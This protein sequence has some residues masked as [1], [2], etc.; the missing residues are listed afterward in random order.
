[1]NSARQDVASVRVRRF[2]EG[3]AREVSDTL[4]V[5]E[6]LEIRVEQ[7]VA[8]ARV[9]QRLA[10]TMRTPG[11][12]AELAVGFLVGE[13]LLRGA[14]DLRD[15]G[16]C[17]GDDASEN[18]VRVS[19]EHPHRE[20]ERAARRFYTTSS[21]G[22][23][24]KGSI[25]ALAVHIGPSQPSV[26][27]APKHL[28]SLPLALR[29][30]Q[31]GF[32]ST[33]GMHGAGLA[34]AG[35]ALVAVREDVGRH[36]AVDKLIGFAFGKGWLPL[37]DHALVLSGRASFELI[38][39]ALVAGIRTVVSVGAPSTLAVQLAREHGCA[40]VGFARPE[41]WNVY[42]DAPHLSQEGA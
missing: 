6:P 24:G 3:S 21:C 13:G 31:P 7:P 4:A 37:S 36:N 30:S 14:S 11:H 20:L 32:S 27:F 12:D 39:K 29:E 8:G 17:R 18:V 28:A 15:V 41:R 19:L 26:T 35:G 34:S 22:V 42:A 9:T 16:R 23:C 33:G 2:S 40:L 5:E 1:M 25:E 38:Q 10:V